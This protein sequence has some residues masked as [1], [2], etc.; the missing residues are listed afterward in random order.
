MDV[1]IRN[2]SILT[3]RLDVFLHIKCVLVSTCWLTQTISHSE[4]S[5]STNSY[6]SCTNSIFY[7]RRTNWVMPCCPL[8]CNNAQGFH[9]GAGSVRKSSISN[10]KFYSAEHCKPNGQSY[11]HLSSYIAATHPHRFFE[12]CHG[13]STILPPRCQHTPIETTTG[14][15]SRLSRRYVVTG[16]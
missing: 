12:A 3:A 11:L 15:R 5:N 16:S 9:V 13:G 6:Y 8:G 1:K 14:G 7:H 10:S 2:T 4:N